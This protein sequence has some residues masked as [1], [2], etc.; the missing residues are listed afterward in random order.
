M[1]KDPEDESTRVL[2]IL[3]SNIGPEG[4]GRNWRIQLGAVA[5]LDDEMPLILPEGDSQRSLDELLR[6]AS[7]G[8]KVS[9]EALRE[10]VLRTLASGEKSREHLNEVAKD[11]LGASANALYERALVPL[12][13]DSR[14]KVR[15][16]GQGGGW[17]WQ[18]W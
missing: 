4:V 7:E 15:K 16:A 12:K 11:E 17:L 6:T 5:G 2:E 13:E 3:K 1:A 18:L 8:R 14:V 9:S 10:L